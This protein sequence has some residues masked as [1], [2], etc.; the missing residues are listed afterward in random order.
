MAQ[1]VLK[2]GHVRPIHAGH[3]WV[4]RQAVAELLGGPKPGAE[5][6]VSDPQ[7]K[8]LGRG[9]YSDSKA[10]AVRVC[11]RSDVALGADFF[12]GRMRRA[13]ALRLRLGLPNQS[14]TGY[15]LVH[16]EADGLPGLIVDVFGSVAS[17]QF[18]TQGMKL[19]EG[20][21]FAALNEVLAPSAILD[22][23][24]PAATRFEGVPAGEGL[25][26]GDPN[27]KA[28]QF[29][30][31]GFDFELPLTLSQ[32]TGFYFDQ[33]DLRARVEQ[34]CSGARVLDVF[35]FVGA[36]GLAAARGGASE[37]LC[38][39]QSPLVVEIAA[40]VARQNGLAERVTVLRDEAEL[41]LQKASR[42]GGYDV[43]LC[44]PPKL[45]PTRASAAAALKHYRNLARAACLATRP[46]GILVFSSCSGA[47]SAS[48][49]Q[50]AI[51]QGARDSN[52]DVTLIEQ[53]VQAGDHPVPAA[54]PEGLYLKSVIARV[55]PIS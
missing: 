53:H 24:S 44:D 15:R 25:V 14:T 42:K 18:N 19:R 26:R 31:R 47:V 9:F 50:R 49:L 45:A 1:V 52:L 17:V 21:V 10:L 22:R 40:T 51:A 20:L 16:G 29:K 30:E 35:S 43:V 32:K 28:L 39:D 23:T 37:V 7:G 13:Q 38:V 4:Y 6:T 5:V 11:T 36:F 46:G 27:I 55:D 48:D 33:R 41:A 34:L 8:F 54:F 2:P 12:V 3:P